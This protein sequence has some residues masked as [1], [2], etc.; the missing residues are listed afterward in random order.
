MIHRFKLKKRHS[1]RLKKLFPL[2]KT[3][4]T[5]CMFGY[6]TAYKS[7]LIKYERIDFE[8]FFEPNNYKDT[9]S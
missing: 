7:I 1:L 3:N 5:G 8:G 6:R 9:K 2:S 4:Y